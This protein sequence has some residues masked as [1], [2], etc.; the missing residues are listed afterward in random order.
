[1]SRHK[2]LTHHH[3]G[4]SFPSLLNFR[5]DIDHLFDDFFHGHM[6]KKDIALPKCNIAETDQSYHIEIQAPGMSEKDIELSLENNVLKIKGEHKH[7]HK[8][9][10][11][12]YHSVE[13]STTSIHRS[14]ELPHNVDTDL[15][16][17]EFKNGIL[18]INLPKKT[19]GQSMRKIEVKKT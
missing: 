9:D 3:D 14:W 15:R 8:E 5:Q 4:F 12:N 7:E 6:S 13:F 11:K 17:A 16:S 2:H 19:S 18:A 1:M 10:K